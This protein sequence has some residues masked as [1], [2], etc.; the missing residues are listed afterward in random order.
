[1]KTLLVL[2]IRKNLIGM[3]GHFFNGEAD[4]VAGPQIGF[5]GSWDRYFTEDR[6]RNYECDDP[7]WNLQWWKANE[8]NYPDPAR[9]ARDLLAVPSAEVDV[10]RLFSEGRDTVGV[11]RMAMDAA[12]YLWIALILENLVNDRLCHLASASQGFICCKVGT[13]DMSRWSGQALEPLQ[14]PTDS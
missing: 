13:G 9:V 8:F 3:N 12:G 14:N 10:E 6:V 4:T 1:M 7:D 11:W 5:G 2:P